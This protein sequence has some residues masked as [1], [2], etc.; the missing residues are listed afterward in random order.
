MASRT[1][2]SL[3]EYKLHSVFGENNVTHTTNTTITEWTSDKVLGSGT[4]GVVWRQRENGTGELRAVKIISK[5]QS[6]TQE[7][8]TL[9]NLRDVCDE[10][11]G[12]V[13]CT[14]LT[15][16]LAFGFVCTI[17]LLV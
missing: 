7:L 4:F 13:L 10:I 14:R 16:P 12:C 15:K 11:C 3:D 5:A 1:P 17:P 9:V 6:N 2:S 8:E